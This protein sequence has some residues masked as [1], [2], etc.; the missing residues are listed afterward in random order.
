[1]E[2]CPVLTSIPSLLIFAGNVATA[3]EQTLTTCVH[4]D[5][6]FYRVTMTAKGDESVKVKYKLEGASKRVSGKVSAL[7]IDLAIAR[8]GTPDGDM[9]FSLLGLSSPVV[10]LVDKDSRLPLQV[11]GQAPRIGKAEINLIEATPADAV[12]AD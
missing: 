9:D 7:K 3:P 11:R 12:Q 8:V 5:N 6:N 10:I 1:M 2:D 4:S